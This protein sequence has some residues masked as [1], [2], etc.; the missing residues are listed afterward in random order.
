MASALADGEGDEGEAVCLFL[1]LCDLDRRL[2]TLDQPSSSPENMASMEVTEVMLVREDLRRPV[3]E[4]AEADLPGERVSGDI[5]EG[6][7][8]VFCEGGWCGEG[9]AK[10]REGERGERE[11]GGE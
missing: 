5:G 7:M 1:F 9:W 8:A 11:R 3:G 4:G 6:T 10:G 2:V